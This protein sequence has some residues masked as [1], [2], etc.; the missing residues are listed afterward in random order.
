MDL[1][2]P[3]AAGIGRCSLFS[4]GG[5]GAPKLCILVRVRRANASGP[6]VCV[7]PFV[8]I[9]ARDECFLV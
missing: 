2:M 6:H 3:R 5:R 8:A 1:G 7:A 4:H 9:P